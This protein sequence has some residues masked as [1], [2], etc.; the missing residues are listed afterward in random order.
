MKSFLA[1]VLGVSLILLNVSQL[2]CVDEEKGDVPLYSLVGMNSEQQ[3][4]GAAYQ[5]SSSAYQALYALQAQHN[6]TAAKKD[7]ETPLLQSDE[8]VQSEYKLTKKLKKDMLIRYNIARAMTYVC[9]LSMIGFSFDLLER[10]DE[11]NYQDS[12]TYKEDDQLDYVYNHSHSTGLCSELITYDGK[13]SK[14]IGR[15]CFFPVYTQ[16]HINVPQLIC[17]SV[18][19]G[20]ATLYDCVKKICKSKK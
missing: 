8:D 19:L 6:G 16:W 4:E 10:S 15:P 9:F 5:D 12:V 7:E 18:G 17:G 1:Y 11:S 2:F 20:L 13:L 14:Y 3:N